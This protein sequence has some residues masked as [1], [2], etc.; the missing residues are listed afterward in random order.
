MIIKSGDNILTAWD[1]PK[2]GDRLFDGEIMRPL[3][4]MPHQLSAA[5]EIFRQTEEAGE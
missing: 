3:I 1:A 2:I 5:K 4:V